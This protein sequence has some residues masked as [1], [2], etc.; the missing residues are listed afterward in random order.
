MFYILLLMIF[1]FYLIGAISLYRGNIALATYMSIGLFM[2]VIGLSIVTSIIKTE[3]EIVVS[4]NKLI[5]SAMLNTDKPIEYT[6]VKRSHPAWTGIKNERYD[7]ISVKVLE[8]SD[9]D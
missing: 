4:K 3:T 2:S 9:N 7:T 6:I 1:L 5:S 8:E